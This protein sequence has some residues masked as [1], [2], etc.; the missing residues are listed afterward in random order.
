MADTNK[1]VSSNVS[2]DFFVDTTCINC[3]TCRQLAP[4]TFA[5]RGDYSY[6]YSQP[7]EESE[8]RAA[9]RALLSCP[10]GSIG[11]RGANLAN[12]VKHE[13]PMKLAENVFY[14]GFNSAKSYGANSFFVT[15]P[16]GNWL[17]D[18]PKFLPYLVDVFEKAGG[19]RYIF[20]THRDD[21]A[22]SD[23]YASKFGAKRIIHRLDSDASPGAEIVLDGTKPDALQ[24]EFLVIPTP[25]H[26]AGHMVLLWKETFL[27]TGDHLAY[28]PGAGRLI[29]FRRACWHSWEEQTESMAWLLQYRF[30]WVLA[31]HGDR[32]HLSADEMHAQLTK[33][34]ERMKLPTNQ[35]SE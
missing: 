16:G 20:L 24:P 5:D 6:V 29:A 28:D 19:I 22:D 11:T 31:G 3:D 13:L 7:T 33:L 17:I 15:N 18:S 4:A 32:V 25:G 14:C 21:V 30:E 26:T 1:A 9:T 8:Q 23:R 35:W 10:T 12:T 34:V 2:G 27:F